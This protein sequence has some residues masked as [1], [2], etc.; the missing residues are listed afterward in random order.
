MNFRMIRSAG[1]ALCFSLAALAL[2]V[3]AASAHPLGNFTINRYTGLVLSP[4]RIDVRYVVDMAEIPTFRESPA[5]DT[6]ADGSLDATE[7]PP[8]RRGSV[9]PASTT[10]WRSGD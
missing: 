6:N 5:I 8:G 9:R 7:R 3:P 2:V 1:V 10:G 4:G